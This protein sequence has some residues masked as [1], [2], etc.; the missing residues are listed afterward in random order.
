MRY[1]L[2]PNGEVRQWA[3]N[4]VDGGKTWV[5]GFDFRYRRAALPD[6]K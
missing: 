4:S 2:L 5:P 1:Q 3:D 6:F